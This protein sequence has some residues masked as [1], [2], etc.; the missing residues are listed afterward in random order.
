MHHIAIFASGAGSNAQKIIEYFRG[1]SRISVALVVCN[2]PGAGVLAIAREAGVETL[3][4]EREPFR[5][6]GYLNEL[7]DRGIDF[8]VLAGFLWKIPDVLIGAYPHRIVNIHPALLPAYGGKGMYGQA[9]HEAVLKAGDR[10]SG[11]TI[12]LVDQWYDHGHILFQETCPVSENESPDSLADKIH[13]LEHAHYP[14]EIE[15]WILGSV[16]QKETF[17]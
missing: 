13:R 17:D 5:A 12:H 2:K 3:L 10:E 6:T 14:R 1:S 15:K 4:V 8:I 7:K 9:V 16:P 11:I